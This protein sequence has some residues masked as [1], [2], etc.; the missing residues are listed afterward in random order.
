[1]RSKKKPILKSFYMKTFRIK[2]H[3]AS[4]T[5]SE[6]HFFILNK[7]LNSGKPL[8]ES[9]P[10]CFVYTTT[11]EIHRDFM[12]W[13]CFALWK[14]KSFHYYLKG[15][16]IPFITLGDVKTH[17]EKSESIASNNFERLNQSIQALKSL[18]LNEQKLNLT[19]KLIDTAKKAIFQ[20]LMYKSDAF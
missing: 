15:S 3:R 11:D 8:K 2:T 6:P 9:C 14:S 17:L 5:Y 19:L 7:G 12:F 10:N 20:Q 13:L 16:V 1:M 18:E 4:L